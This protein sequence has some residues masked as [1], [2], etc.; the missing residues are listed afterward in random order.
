LFSCCFLS[1]CRLFACGLFS[2]GLLSR[3]LLSRGLRSFG[4]P[5]GDGLRCGF[6]SVLCS[7]ELRR[8]RRLLL[9]RALLLRNSIIFCFARCCFTRC[10]LK[11]DSL[12]LGSFLI[13]REICRSSSTRVEYS[14]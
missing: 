13:W 8:Q 14:R 5:S 2:Q 4:S 7:L 3:R 10:R 6:L 9:P 12:T 11:G 1:R